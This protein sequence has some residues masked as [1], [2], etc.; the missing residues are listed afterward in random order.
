MVKCF[1]HKPL[2]C[3]VT[4]IHGAETAV[5]E[6]D[7]AFFELQLQYRFGWGECAWRSHARVRETG[8][9]RGDKRDIN[10][11]TESPICPA[12]RGA[13]ADF[14]S[15]V[16]LQII[17]Q[18]VNKVDHLLRMGRMTNR[19]CMKTWTHGTQDCEGNRVKKCMSL[20][21]ICVCV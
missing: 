9:R 2:K 6:L 20:C 21:I 4:C 12:R 14:Y 7:A 5:I 19:C 3:F 13:A 18:A 8:G 1:S 17:Y 15:P 10:W 16:K 11:N